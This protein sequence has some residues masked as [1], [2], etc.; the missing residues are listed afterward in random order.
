[1]L[2]SSETE[3]IY[4]SHK[5]HTNDSAQICLTSTH[6]LA[7]SAANFSE[8]FGSKPQSAE[9]VSLPL[10]DPAAGGVQYIRFS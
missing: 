4:K 5:K 9:I 1:M 6:W 8:I 7:K 3:T 2:I 10:D